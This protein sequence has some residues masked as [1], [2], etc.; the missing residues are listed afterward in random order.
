MKVCN[1][2]STVLFV[3]L[4]VVVSSLLIL[5]F[6]GNKRTFQKS[7]VAMG[8]VITQTLTGKI[9]QKVATQIIDEIKNL[10]NNELSWRVNAS[11]VSKINQ[12]TKADVS[13]RTIDFL[14]SALSFCENSGGSFDVTIG[15][16]SSL[17]NIGS[18]NFKVPSEKE[19]EDAL[20]NIDFK[21]IKINGNSVSIQKG[22]TLDFGAT[23]KGIACDEAKKIL[24][25]N[26]T[27][28]SAIISA[29]GSSV[30][31]YSKNKNDLFSIGIR[32]P[33]KG[34]N[35]FFGI[36]KL[37]NAFIS[38][39]GNYEKVS[40][41]NGKTYH[42]ILDPVTGYPAENN[43]ASVTVIS[44]SGFLSDALSTACYVLGYNKSIELLK[45]YDAEAVFVF[46]N[47]SVKLTD[48]FSFDFEITNTSFNLV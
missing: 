15:S 13:D 48:S 46:K 25:K 8:T 39:S 37:T 40:T 3:A 41:Y 19:I 28:T 4:L 27:I 34:D 38:T 43:L 9:S 47:H 42:H 1:K 6:I 10:E 36:L 18:E 32:D 22:Q 31:T 29:G 16:L 12:N 17:W 45:K 5:D 21:K 44:S 26:S 7:D 14:K 11:D 35:S 2:K 33:I 24:Q 23:G 30:F 20:K